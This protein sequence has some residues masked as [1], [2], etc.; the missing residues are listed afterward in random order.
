MD[1][2]KK[3]LRFPVDINSIKGAESDL[4]KIHRLMPEAFEFVNRDGEE[5]WK[6]K[7]EEMQRA[8]EEYKRKAEEID[9]QRKDNES[10]RQKIYKEDGEFFAKFIAQQELHLKEIKNRFSLQILNA[11]IRPPLPGPA[12]TYGK[13]TALP[14]TRVEGV[15]TPPKLP[16]PLP[17]IPS[18]RTKTVD[19]LPLTLPRLDEKK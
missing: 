4:L 14:V 5:N 1:T 6:R 9:S 17:S 8:H 18:M 2:F 15:V 16:V 13:R 19:G 12:K 3:D 7:Y 11:A 10:K